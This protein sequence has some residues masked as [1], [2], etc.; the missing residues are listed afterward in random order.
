[1]TPALALAPG[2][3][4]TTF[5][6]GMSAPVQDAQIRVKG[7][8]TGVRVTDSGGS[9]LAMPDTAAGQYTRFDMDS[10]RCYQTTTNVWSGGTEVSGLVDFGGPRGVFEL[11][12][13]NSAL[14][15]RF[16][17]ITVATTTTSGGTLEV[18]GRAAYAL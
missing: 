6:N 10:G 4:T 2:N 16:A 9:W 7:P 8:A 11:I 12:D 18:R 13:K 15:N 14:S 1:M 3:V 5:W 17:S